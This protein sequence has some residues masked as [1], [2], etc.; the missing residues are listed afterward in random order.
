V[1]R[2]TVNRITG[3]FVDAAIRA[4]TKLGPGLLESAYEAALLYEL[5]KRELSAQT[6]VAMPVLYD[7]IRIDLGY[8]LDLLVEGHVI[9]E[10][11]SVEAIEE[12]H[13][14]QMLTYL[15]LSGRPIGLLLNFNV[16]RMKD[17]IIRYGS[18]ADHT[19]SP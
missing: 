14:A 11:K 6:Q 10:I 2:E 4:H 19:S 18:F 12:V 7:E 5:H 16:P 17:G 15:R 8:R 1:E 3:K 9:V 13:K